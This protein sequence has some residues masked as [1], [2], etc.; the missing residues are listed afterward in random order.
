MHKNPFE[1]L[2]THFVTA[3]LLSQTA[4]ASDPLPIKIEDGWVRAVPPSVTDTAAFMRIENTGD[5]PLR[6]TGGNCSIAGMGMLMKTTRQMVQG[7]EVLG[8]GGLDFIDIP[9]HSGHIL[10]PGGDHL[11]LMNITSHPHP[12]DLVTVTLEFDPGHQTVT[13]QL[14]ARIDLEK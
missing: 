4:L 6:L 12:G 9:P 1:H 3:L 14:P 2:L 7:V 11:M 13:V 8:M 5:T 10:K